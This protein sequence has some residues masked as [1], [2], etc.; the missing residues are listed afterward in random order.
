[1]ANSNEKTYALFSNL[2]NKKIISELESRGTKVFQF[3]PVE[4]VEIVPGEKSIAN[5]KNLKVFD[6]I[7]FPDV[8]TVD[9]FLQILEKYEVN[10]F[11]MDSVQVCAFG[12][13]VADRL[14]FVQLHADVIPTSVEAASV[15]LALSDYVGE[16]ELSDLKFLLPKEISQEYEIKRK[17]VE[18]GANVFELPVYQ[19]QIP[20][21]NEITKLKALLKGGAIDEFIFSSAT[22]LIALKCCFDNDSISRILSEINISAVDKAILQ[23]LR[24]YNLRANYF[25]LK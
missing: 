25:Q 19:A 20:R 13:V 15:F 23:T 10:L 3:P 17:L 18:S 2:T 6:W 21:V 12:E 4:T 9:Y 8:L 24:E 16:D 11:E 7:I 22:D 5:I 1:M 14:R